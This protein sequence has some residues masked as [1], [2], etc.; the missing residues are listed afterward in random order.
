MKNVHPFLIFLC[1]GVFPGLA[2]AMNP[3]VDSLLRVLES[4][5]PGN[6][7]EVLWGIAY[8]LFDVN[9]SEALFYDEGL[10][11]GVEGRRQPANCEGGDNL[12]T[13]VA[14]DGSGGFIDGRVNPLITHRPATRLS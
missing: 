8:E 14:E 11:G 9:N 4:N 13:I 7:V 2:P 12:W 5:A 6:K 1:L 3:K 10:P